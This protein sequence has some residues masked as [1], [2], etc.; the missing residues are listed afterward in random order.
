MDGYT[1]LS[2]AYSDLGMEL[3][4]ASEMYPVLLAALL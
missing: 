1:L 4:G 3:D 2:S